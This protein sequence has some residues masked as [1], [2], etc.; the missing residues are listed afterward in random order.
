M[1]LSCC[2]CL[3]NLADHHFSSRG[4]TSPASFGTEEDG[5][6]IG[7]SSSAAVSAELSPEPNRAITSEPV[8]TTSNVSLSQK[9]VITTQ[10]A[11][12]FSSSLTVTTV[13]TRE[14][15]SSSEKSTMFLL[16]QSEGE[17]FTVPTSLVGP[18]NI[19][20][21][22]EESFTGGSFTLP[23]L[24][25]DEP[26]ER[27][28][29]TPAVSSLEE[30][31]QP[32]FTAM[33]TS[34][35]SLS[36]PTIMITTAG[37][38]PSFQDD[39]SVMIIGGGILPSFQETYSSR[40][41]R[42]RAQ[43]TV[44]TFKY[45]EV[46]PE[47][48]EPTSTSTEN[49]PS[50]F[51][52]LQPSTSSLSFHLSEPIGFYR[53]IESPLI[54][55]VSPS[56][57]AASATYVPS[58]YPS[59]PLTLHEPTFLH[60]ERLEPEQI[61]FSSIPPEIVQSLP[62]TESSTFNLESSH[63]VLEI[64]HPTEGT[65]PSKC[66]TFS[67]QGQASATVPSCVIP[68]TSQQ[69]R[70]RAHTSLSTP[71][72]KE[73]TSSTSQLC[74]VCGDKAACQHYGVR[75]CEGCKGFFKRTVQKGANYVCLGNKSCPVDKRR[76]NRCQFCRFQKCLAVGMNKEVIR[77]HTLKGRRGRLPSSKKVCQESPPSL[78][79]TLISTLVRAHMDTSPD[80]ANLNYSKLREPRSGESMPSE[81]EQVQLVFSLITSSIE[82]IRTFAEK[83]PGFTEFNR[84]DKELLFEAA[85]LELFVLRLSYR[86]KMDD[87]RLTFCCGLVLHKEECRRGFGDWLD[88][89]MDFA[90]SLH[91]LEID[92]SC[93][94]CL[95]ALVLVTER[96]GLKE[97]K[98][99]DQLQM[100]IVGTLRDHVTY[101]IA[102]QRR[103]NLFSHILGRIP[104]LRSVSVQGFHRLFYLKLE[105][106]VPIPPLVNRLLGSG[107]PL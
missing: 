40:Y 17:S 21:L 77:S 23:A 106:L 47:Q 8:S 18:E 38:L 12:G 3:S 71:T 107:V 36:D 28:E 75:T 50:S 100:K 104:D 4:T 80:I 14:T 90:T 91:D 41:R 87:D 1:L 51:I 24:E 64:S 45:K 37:T 16:Q 94:A 99:I 9:G 20:S 66:T 13:T 74:A 65:S 63:I 72:T 22:S 25:F 82:I 11:A 44:L 31:L 57:Q 86:M 2:A 103:T 48:H 92:I 15:V 76:R 88:S 49:F 62:M 61:P 30:I 70:L 84:E 98:K 29:A 27:F 89:I 81:A 58:S 83:V 85:F 73:P 32:E 67:V 102:I 52:D 34:T 105:N 35:T 55:P 54:S 93:F 19:L 101:N 78:P 56:S 5:S 95:C 79:V 39:S 53:T 69:Q 43:S 42:E 46:S 97:P 26:V 60:V 59:P 68:Q 33:M 6:G 96:H 7:S 10:I